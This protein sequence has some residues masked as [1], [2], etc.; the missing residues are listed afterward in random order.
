M[1]ISAKEMSKFSIKN[2]KTK[3]SKQAKDI[4]TQDKKFKYKGVEHFFFNTR[5]KVKKKRSLKLLMN[6][7]QKEK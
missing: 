6:K 4:F 2:Q 7:S 5:S 3:F 1:P